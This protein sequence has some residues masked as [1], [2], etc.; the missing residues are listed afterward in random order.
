MKYILF[1]LYNEN[2]IYRNPDYSKNFNGNDSIV[3]LKFDLLL[4]ITS[5][6]SWGVWSYYF[7]QNEISKWSKS[8]DES[9]S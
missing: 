3:W 7:Q 1:R 4:L 5:F 9:L 2:G 8:I 6:L